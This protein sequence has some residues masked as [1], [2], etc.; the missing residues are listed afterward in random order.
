[1]FGTILS[2]FVAIFMLF[3]PIPPDAS[4]GINAMGV[5]LMII[6][7]LFILHANGIFAM[8]WGPLQLVE[9]NLTPRTLDIL[10][11][12]LNLNVS[13]HWLYVFPLATFVIA[14]DMMFF[15]IVQKNILLSIWIL[16]FGISLD[17]MQY[18]QRR[19]L[20]YLNP[21]S[22]VEMFTKNAE[23]SVRNEHELELCNWI[24]A[25]AEIAL[26]SIQKH[27]TSLGTHAINEMP[28]I[29][30]TFLESSKS[31]S[32]HE[33]DAETKALGIQ[34]KVSFTLFYLFQRLEMLNNKGLENRLEPICSS[35]VT[36]LGKISIYAAKYDL[37]MTSYPLHFIGRF[38]HQAQEN[39]MQDVALK[40]NFI[41]L[42]IAKT[43]ITEID[44]TYQELKDP[45][46]SIIT[47]LNEIAKET[48]R[49]DKNTNINILIQPFRDL[50][51]LL[52]NPRIASHQDLPIIQQNL[53][54]VLG[55]FAALEA[56]LKTIPPIPQ[57]PES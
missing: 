45:M 31:I 37:T 47:H 22:V 28:V 5:I 27:S 57:V 24:D 55:E 14:S 12:D 10:R 17:F 51:E 26:K 33:Q 3:H 32:H 52:N 41:L 6:A 54:R 40:T 44:V 56:V 2:L 36:V 25:L 43:I 38:A 21:F 19:I 29:A 50:K 11:K 34:D 15:N 13:Y 35:L 7:T 16:F 1:M 46:L 49:Q 18:Y 48:F 23:E 8:A 53:D 4:L 39:K 30:K 20:S 42:E 9:Q